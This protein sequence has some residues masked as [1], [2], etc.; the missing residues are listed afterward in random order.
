MLPPPGPASIG[1]A[2]QDIDGKQQPT[3]D[4]STFSLEHCLTKDFC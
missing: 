1:L 4:F 2:D 3:P